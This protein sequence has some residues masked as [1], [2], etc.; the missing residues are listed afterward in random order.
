MLSS[1]SL[2]LLMRNKSV[3]MKNVKLHNIYLLV[4]VFWGTNLSA[5]VIYP[6]M[7]DDFEDGT[8]NSWV[9]GPEAGSDLAPKN[10]ANSDESNRYLEVKSYGAGENSRDAGSRMV[11]FN[12][13][14]WAGDYTGIG[15]ISLT[16]K[17]YSST[18]E[19]LYM[20]LAIFD[21]APSGDYSRYVST[22]SQQLLAD[23]KWHTISLSLVAEDLTRYRGEQSA[24][25]V[26]T[27]VSHLRIL[28]SENDVKGWGVDKI[29]ATLSIDN[30]TA[31]PFV[32]AQSAELNAVP[33]PATLWFMI[34]GLLG[35]TGISFQQKQLK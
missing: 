22:T 2:L 31:T 8:T 33:V 18:E 16:M 12:E 5:N 21:N 7:I 28:S 29:S 35:L 30:I 25:E 24:S 15:S 23:D 32:S 3:E 14:Q 20:R 13:S 10:L 9:K 27:N 26:L 4:L 11:F 6:G 19:A 1:I 17:A 34:S